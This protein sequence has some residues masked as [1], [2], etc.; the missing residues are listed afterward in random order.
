MMCRIAYLL[1]VL[2]VLVACQEQPRQEAI[3]F[4]ND[5][6]LPI[7]P[8]K[9][10]RNSDL[11]WAYAMLAT[12]ETEHIVQGDSVNLSAD[13]VARHLLRELT[14]DSYLRRHNRPIS[15]R[16]M[17]PRLINRIMKDGLLSYDSYHSNECN[18]RVLQRKLTNMAHVAA[19]RR[20]SR[21][22]F[23]QKVEQTLDDE[24]RPVPRYQFMYGAEYTTRE[25][26]HS[27]C[28]PDEYVALTSYTHRPFGQHMVLDVPDNTDGDAFLNLPMD[29]LLT[30]VEQSVRGGHPVCWEGD[31]SEPGFD[32]AAGLAVTNEQPSQQLRQQQF[33][34]KGTTDDHCM[35]IVG[36]ATDNQGRRYFI[37]KNSWGKNN[38]YN[39]LV[40]MSFDYFF[41][42]TIAVVLP[43]NQLVAI[44]LFSIDFLPYTFVWNHYFL[45]SLRNLEQKI[46]TNPDNYGKQPIVP[47]RRE[48]SKR[49]TLRARD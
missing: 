26:A 3:A 11:C 7:T 31:I 34:T 24:I 1:V 21:A 23:A 10:Q 46:N 43:K 18:Y 12:I 9:D 20:I 30:L 4:N 35:S 37:C 6:L 38:P 17:A 27:V 29:S 14:L 5:V 47:R 48:S 19:N 44:S 32:F 36:L 25:F 45:L 28:L 40:Y 16:G 39:G 13:F 15:L 22:Q 33:E 2:A 49:A 42:K 41:L 8:V